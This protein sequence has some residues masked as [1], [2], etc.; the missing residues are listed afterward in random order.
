MHRD[1]NGRASDAEHQRPVCKAVDAPNGTGPTLKSSKERGAGGWRG[2]GACED[3]LT[4]QSSSLSVQ[5]T[6]KPPESVSPAHRADEPFKPENP[7]S[8]ELDLGERTSSPHTVFVLIGILL[9]V[10]LL[11]HYYYY[12]QLS[13][14]VKVKIGLCAA[15]IVFIGFAA[16]HLPDSL[17][18]RPH[19]VVWRAVLALGVLY[20]VF[21]TFMIFQDME[22]VRS[23]MGYYDESLL[24]PLPERSYAADCRITTKEDPWLLF[25]T[26]MDIFVL[27]HSLGYIVKT[28]V[29]RDWRM[30]MAVSLGFEVIE[31]TFQHVLPN[32]RECW[33]DHIILD[34][35]ICNTGGMLVGMWLLRQV[36]AKQYKWI[37]LK[38]APTVRGKAKRLLRQLGPRSFERY[39][40]NIFQ[41]STRFFQVSGI[42]L[43]I[44]LQE[45]NCFT[46]K[47]ILQM[48]PTHHLVA[49]R[50]TLWAL[51]GTSALREVYEFM[52]NPRVKRI[53][54]AAWVTILALVMETTW[55]IKMA[56]EGH[57][58]QDACMPIHVLVP[59]MAA[60]ASFLIWLVLY[61]GVLSLEQRNR[62][63]GVAHIVVNFFFYAAVMS[64]LA[65]FLM[66]LPDLQIGRQAFESAM[67]P[68]E[69][70]I[71]SWR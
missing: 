21:L 59:W 2:N 44:L 42:L 32:F 36:N 52:T 63:W 45:L 20:L 12:P 8:D 61:F 39:N 58:F 49:A 57:Y 47:A 30:V 14:V 69:R 26:A 19:P 5:S 40:W 67:A 66:G 1:R 11:L 6:D 51:L 18:V 3:H 7:S 24:R 54:T 60:I 27:A 56:V 41:S 15:S 55:I 16:V 28:L 31:V 13:V 33:W 29:L 43:L 35:L 50:L 22:T 68:Y 53:G 38:E 9:F 10:L 70:Y 25:N 23:I 4:L 64:V 17:I 65:L 46:L 34:V 62:R 71:T 48:E 37:A